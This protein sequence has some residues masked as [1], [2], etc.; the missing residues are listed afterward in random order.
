MTKPAPWHDDLEIMKAMLSRSFDLVAAQLS[1]ATRALMNQ[2]ESLGLKVRRRD[3]QVDQLEVEIDHLCE[4]VLEKY[5]PDADDTRKIVTSIKINTDLERIGDYSANLA[6]YIPALR[7]LA[8][9]VI[10]TSGI[11]GL[12]MAVD[13]V[14]WE[15]RSAFLSEDP[16]A[17]QKLLPLDLEVDKVYQ[18]VFATV[19]SLFRT[20]PAQAPSLA[21]LLIAVKS[22]E[23]LS[24]HLM[25]IAESVVFR[26]VGHDIRHARS[27]SRPA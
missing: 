7:G 1:D 20:H 4:Q 12:A 5:Q 2:D 25:N 6:K 15:T 23:R 26:A 17:A 13:R 18:Q 9:D 21:Y 16:D 8:P 24:D 3:D 22:L 14:L 19:V 10:A 27:A 11:E